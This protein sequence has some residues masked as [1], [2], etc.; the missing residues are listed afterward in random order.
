MIDALLRPAR[1]AAARALTRPLPALGVYAVALIAW[2]LPG[3]Y[4][5]ALEVHGWHIVQHLTLMAAATLAWWPVF[6]RSRH[7]AP[8]AVRRPDPLSVRVRV[9][10]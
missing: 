3:P 2:H 4:G 5:L 1:C 10:R 8:P 6:G 7:R 9:A